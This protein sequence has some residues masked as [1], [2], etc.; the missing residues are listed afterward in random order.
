MHNALQRAPPTPAAVTF[1]CP[2]FATFLRAPCVCKLDHLEAQLGEGDCD[3]EGWLLLAM[4]RLPRGENSAE[5]VLNTVEVSG[6]KLY[7][8]V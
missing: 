3:V 4:H 8:R 7:C 6:G 1:I 2:R 5:A